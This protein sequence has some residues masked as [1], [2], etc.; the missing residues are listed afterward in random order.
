MSEA[1]VYPINKGAESRAH[2]NNDQYR[3]MYEA[4]IEQSEEFWTQQAKE[5]LTWFKPWNTLTES[6][7]GK[8]EARWFVGGELNASYN[9]IDRHLDERGDQV[10]IIWE[11]DDPNDDCKITYNEL[12]EK[13]CRMANALKTRG[14]KKGDRVCIYMP[15][16][17]EAAY[18]M[19]ACT[20]IGAIHSV[21]FGG[22]SPQALQDR[23]LDSDCQTLITADE[24]VRGARPI[25][26]KSNADK[27]L[28]KC[29]NVHTVL[30]VQ[31]T[32]A[33]IAWND[34]RDAWYHSAIESESA[35]C[36][37]EHMGSEDP[38]F[39]LYT[40]GSTGKP[41]G[42]L[43]TTGGYLLQAALTHKYVFDY[44][45]GDIYWCTADVGWV[46]GHTYIVYGPLANGAT[47]LM[48]EGLPTYPDSSRCWQVVDKHQVNIFYTAPTALRALMAQG[49]D[50]VTQTSRQSLHLLGTVGEPINPEAWEW[51]YHT[52]G[53]QKCPIVDTWWQTETGGIMIT[54]LPGATALKPGSATRPFFGVKPVLL[55]TDGNEIEGPG[56]GNLAI[57]RSWPGQIRTVFGDH[58][59][60]IE[61]YYS[62]YKGYY[63]T[64]D[65][66]RRD[67]DGY[68][69]I[70]GRVDDVLN[71]SG[72]RMGTAE[73]ESALVLHEK[74]AEAA[75]V[76]FP[77]SIKGQG[78]Y[79]YVTLMHDVEGTDELKKELNQMVRSEIG[80][81]A[82]PDVL[83][84]APGLPKTRSGKIMRRILRKIAENELDSLGDTSTL[85]DPAVVEDLIENSPVTE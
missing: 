26:L 4:S 21:V 84:W 76:G 70:T 74:V 23:I 6:D 27:A 28:E 32:G 66:A 45:E 34:E 16:I 64:G 81:I 63:F 78:I 44:H 35:N 7:F 50:F 73:V 1:K 83:Q 79:A 17:P 8:G 18:A 2:L 24:G 59:R 14:V 57:D 41:K 43:H 54:P 71:I 9:C 65:G 19:L 67:E 36:E 20:R 62:S 22:F 37:P 60:C 38:L 52:V 56:S 49:D 13:V 61:T 80:A 75:V 85:A 69:W 51:Y 72:H 53:E 30:V 15:M 82:K 12:H 10:A 11:G 40:S 46:T 48:F 55:D 42:V 39:I 68:Y 58:D 5:F 31:R 77:H 33:D 25:P 3:A 29:P 47:T